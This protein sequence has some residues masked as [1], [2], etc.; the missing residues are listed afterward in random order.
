MQIYQKTLGW[1]TYIKSG[2]KYCYISSIKLIYSSGSQPVYRE[3][4]NGIIAVYVSYAQ[5]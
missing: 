2:K 3:N 4:F 1:F 5:I